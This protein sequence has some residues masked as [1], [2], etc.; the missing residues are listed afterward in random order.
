MSET[1]INYGYGICI[2]KLDIDSVERIE[3]LLSLAPEYQHK[4]H[5]WFEFK[6]YTEPTVDNYFE[7]DENSCIGL[8]TI[9]R[10]ALTE[11]TGITF[12]ECDDCEGNDYV[13][14]KPSYPWSLPKNETNLTKEQIKDIFVKYCSII[15]DTPIEPEYQEAENYA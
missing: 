13:I 15:T 6:G 12:T 9:I 14:Y 11:I 2:S 5:D 7:Y 8:T 10:E 1:F 4:V 3:Q